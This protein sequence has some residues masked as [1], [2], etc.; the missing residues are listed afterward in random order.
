MI[1]D[2]VERHGKHWK[3]PVFR[4]L[5]ILETEAADKEADQERST[6]DY[7]RRFGF[8]R[9]RKSGAGQLNFK[10]QVGIRQLEGINGKILGRITFTKL[11]TFFR[12]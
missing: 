6:V 8:R 10:L 11:K 12:G 4:W 2:I 9:K 5:R 7:S 3:S 1:S